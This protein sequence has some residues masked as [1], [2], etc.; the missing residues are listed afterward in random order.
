MAY[1]SS[2][3]VSAWMVN[4]G[5]P[6]STRGP[7]GACRSTP[8]AAARGAPPRSGRSHDRGVLLARR[9]AHPALR[10]ADRL[11]FAPRAPVAENRFGQ[12]ATPPARSPR[13]L[14]QDVTGQQQRPFAEI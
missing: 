12:R 9:L 5:C 4:R 6:T 13:G 10:V 14:L 8:P 11:K 1:A 7:K 3:G 2:P